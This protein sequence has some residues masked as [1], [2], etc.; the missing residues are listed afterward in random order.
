M[1]NEI[2]LLFIMDFFINDQFIN[3]FCDESYKKW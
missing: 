3:V 1:M 2:M